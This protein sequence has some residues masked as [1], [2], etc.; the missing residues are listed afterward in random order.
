MSQRPNGSSKIHVVMG[1]TSVT[2]V[3]L[4]A[5]FHGKYAKT[6]RDVI[7]KGLQI[8][9]VESG[10]IPDNYFHGAFNLNLGINK[11][12]EYD[13]KWVIYS[14]DDMY[15]IDDISILVGQLKKLNN[16]DYDAIFIPE[17]TYHSKYLFIG[18]PT[19]L[20]FLYLLLKHRKIGKN[21]VEIYK[22]FDIKYVPVSKK[23]ILS[24]T[25]KRILKYRDIVDFAILS[26]SYIK[27]SNGKFFDEI[28]IN[29]RGDSDLSL[30]L[31]NRLERIGFVEFNIGD[32]VGSSFGLGL[33]REMRGFASDIYFSKKFEEHYIN[34]AKKQ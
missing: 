34:N 3:I 10:E 9:F 7:F 26:P 23:A 15:K 29:Q 1:D 31:H 12:L 11:A 21:I 16:K 14:S 33:N 32:Y 22:K 4:T 25:F 27:K 17:S 2:V 8:I 5:D 30:R 6:C 24:M 13:P 18:S 20:Y 28:Y 19:K